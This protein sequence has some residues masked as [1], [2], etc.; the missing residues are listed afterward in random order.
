MGM[1]DYYEPDPSLRCPVCDTPL[2]GWQGKCGPNALLVWR[3]GQPHPVDQLVSDDCKVNHEDI[4][5][6]VLPEHFDI[7]TPCCGGR[8]FVTALC[9]APGGLWLCTELVTAANARQ[10]PHER[11]A[12]FK[13]RMR[14]LQGHAA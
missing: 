6:F 7:R 8:F 13:A 5:Q 3:Q 4:Q 2:S 14:W 10:L 1:F 11:R 9:Q 12:D